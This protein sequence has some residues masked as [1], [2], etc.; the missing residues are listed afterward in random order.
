M[1]Q[2]CCAWYD[3]HANEMM[4]QIMLVPKGDKTVLVV[5]L[6]PARPLLRLLLGPRTRLGSS[7]KDAPFDLSTRE[8]PSTRGRR[9][10]GLDG[11]GR[12]DSVPDTLAE[13]GDALGRS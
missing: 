12:P 3:N 1:I 5:A 8:L 13:V 4:P 11:R 9:R 10:V 2:E 7:A 6:E